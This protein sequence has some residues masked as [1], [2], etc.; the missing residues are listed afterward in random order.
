MWNFLFL[1]DLQKISKCSLICI[2]LCLVRVEIWKNETMCKISRFLSVLD[3][4]LNTWTQY[5]LIVSA[6]KR[7]QLISTFFCWFQFHHITLFLIFV[8]S[9]F[10]FFIYN[11]GKHVSKWVFPLNHTKNIFAFISIWYFKSNS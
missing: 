8:L 3:S 7:F 2:Y 10:D 11:I 4:I 5:L 6:L 1:C 9:V